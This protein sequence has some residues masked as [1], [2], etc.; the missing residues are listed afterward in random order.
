MHGHPGELHTDTTDAPH[1]D[2]DTADGAAPLREA[3]HVLKIT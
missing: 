3:C 2:T 1:P